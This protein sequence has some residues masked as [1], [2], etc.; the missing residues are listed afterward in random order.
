MTIMVSVISEYFYAPLSFN[1]NLQRSPFFDISRRWVSSSYQLGE[2]F[3][4][5]WQRPRAF[6]ATILIIAH[7]SGPVERESK[8][9]Q[10]IDLHGV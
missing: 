7:I 2:S 8:S 1:S 9:L 6:T 5:P 10:E 3:L 4:H